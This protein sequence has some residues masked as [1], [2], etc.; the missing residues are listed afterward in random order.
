M[1]AKSVTRLT[2]HDETSPLKEE[3]SRSIEFMIVTLLTSHDEI[4]PLK[5]EAP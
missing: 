2:S 5:E 3:A 1:Y 4:S